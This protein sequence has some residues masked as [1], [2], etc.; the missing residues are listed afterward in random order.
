M[1]AGF[2]VVCDFGFGVAFPISFMHAKK[3]NCAKLNGDFGEL[4]ES[5]VRFTPL[6]SPSPSPGVQ[7]GGPGGDLGVKP[8]V[9]FGTC[10]SR[11]LAE[12]SADERTGQP[13]A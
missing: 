12:G 10:S 9:H 6:P 3:K 1:S 7:G 4:G 13:V 2:S 11:Q 8:S 5:I